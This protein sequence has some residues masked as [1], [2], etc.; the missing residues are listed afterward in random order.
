MQAFTAQSDLRTDSP[1][2]RLVHRIEDDANPQSEQ[3]NRCGRRRTSRGEERENQRENA[4]ALR[5][6]KAGA[7]MFPGE[8]R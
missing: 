7:E 3:V 8:G 4:H 2:I 5:K 1:L 6:T